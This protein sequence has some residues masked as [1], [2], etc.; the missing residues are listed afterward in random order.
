MWLHALPAAEHEQS[1]LLCQL[2]RQL[3]PLHQPLRPEESAVAC[4]VQLYRVAA[5]G[6]VEASPL[7]AAPAPVPVFA[8]APHPPVS[9]PLPMLLPTPL[10][11]PLPPPLLLPPLPPLPP[12]SPQLPVRRAEQTWP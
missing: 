2:R 12:P 1:Q 5:L 3:P 7:P 9:T 8:P 6:L 11:T 4:H 10:P